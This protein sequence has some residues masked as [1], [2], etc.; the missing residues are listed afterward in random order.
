M[1]KD[2]L[3]ISPIYSVLSNHELLEKVVP[4]YDIENPISCEVLYE[5]ANDSY[6]L[7][8]EN[9]IYLMRVYSQY[10]RTKTD[11]EFEVEALYHLHT[12]D[13][14]I[15]YPIKR[16]DGNF[17]TSVEAPEGTRY[18]IIT[19]YANGKEIWDGDSNDWALYG[20]QVAEIHNQSN[21]F[22]SDANR[23]EL[24]LTLLIDEPLRKIEKFLTHRPDDWKFLLEYSKELSEIIS[25]KDHK[26]LDFGFCHGDFHGGNAHKNNGQLTFFDFDCCG[27]GYRAY[28]LAVFKWCSR[29]NGKEDERWKPF[30]NSYKKNREFSENDFELIEP[31]I[32]IRHIWLMGF[33]I[34]HTPSIGAFTDS[35]FCRCPQ[36]KYL[37]VSRLPINY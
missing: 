33:H 26:S 37:K 8:T 34:T 21:D 10:W 14:K 4:L 1:E 25:N 9:D 20:K 6:K 30:I 24:D 18:V 11:I 12:K 35:Y 7:K 5:G 3:H 32:S 17:I 28:D 23:F 27:N 2:K 29:L 36:K 31:Y 15:S 19:T 16:K 13:V 22:S